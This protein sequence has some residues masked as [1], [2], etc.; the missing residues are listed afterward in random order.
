MKPTAPGPPDAGCGACEPEPGEGRLSSPLTSPATASTAAVTTA[1]EVSGPKVGL[2][3]V[4]GDSFRVG[5]GNRTFQAV[6]DLDSHLAV[7]AG[8]QEQDS[9]IELAPP[10]LPGLCHAEAEIFEHLAFETGN[11]QDGHLS[12]G[13]FLQL[14][15]S[16]FDRG[17]GI[18]GE[19]VGEIVDSSGEIGNFEVGSD[20]V[21]CKRRSQEGRKRKLLYSSKSLGSSL[22]SLVSSGRRLTPCVTNRCPQASTASTTEA[23]FLPSRNPSA[24]FSAI[25]SQ[26]AGGTCSS[27][28][29]C[30]GES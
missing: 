21:E 8:D 26:A 29:A 5:I 23:P 24:R 27:T 18:R 9:V 15:E 2:H 4:V 16:C 3:D 14:L 19:E 30:P 10:E 20:G 7:I 28:P 11:G 25:S 1:I 17:L 13:G 6:T 22:S 12:P